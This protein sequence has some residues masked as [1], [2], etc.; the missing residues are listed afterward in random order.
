MESLSN[1]GGS[2]SF[3]ISFGKKQAYSRI[4]SLFGGLI[5][6]LLSCTAF[7]FLFSDKELQGGIPFI[8]ESINSTIGMMLI[9]S[10]ALLT[11]FLAIYA[12]Y[13]FWQG[14]GKQ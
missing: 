12:F 9:G 3:K 11:G 10:G 14:P 13:E 5:C 7:Y 1:P 2:M 4:S 6:L 8:P